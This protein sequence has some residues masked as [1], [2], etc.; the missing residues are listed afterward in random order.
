MEDPRQRTFRAAAKHVHQ[1]LA[2]G[3]RTVAVVLQYPEFA[4]IEP[5]FA[6]LAAGDATLHSGMLTHFAGANMTGEWRRAMTCG[7]E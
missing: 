5:V 6:Q 1:F 2:T 4:S 3:G 7:E